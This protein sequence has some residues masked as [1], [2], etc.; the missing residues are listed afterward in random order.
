[1]VNDSP[2]GH[3]GRAYATGY[4]TALVDMVSRHSP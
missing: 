4:I 2:W 3:R 1:M